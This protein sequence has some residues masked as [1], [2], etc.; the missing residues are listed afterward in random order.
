MA[1]SLSVNAVQVDFVS[2]LSMEHV[3]IVKMFKSLEETGLKGFLGVNC[4]LFWG[5]VIEFFANAKVITGTIVS[6]VV[7]R[8]MVVTKDVIAEAFG[9]PIEGM[10]GFTDLLAQSVAEMRMRFS[11]T[12]VPFRAPNKK[13]E[14]K[15]EYRLLHEIME[16]AM[17]AKAGSFDVVTSEKFD[18]MVAISAVH[19]SVLLEK[20]VKAY[21]RESVKLHPLKLLNHK[22][23]TYMKKNLAVGPFG[24][25][26]NR[27]LK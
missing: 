6:F 15:V 12:D 8:K 2:V 27:Q 26:R 3:G 23:L 10:V 24:E 22:S 19:M 18:L 5:A 7:N 4:S 13:K 16:K 20:L 9:L 11:G 17:C 14:M 21:L 1:A 25:S